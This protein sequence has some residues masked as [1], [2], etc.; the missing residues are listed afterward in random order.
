MKKNKPKILIFG[1]SGQIGSRASMLFA[2]DFSVFTPSHREVDVTNRNQVEEIINQIK[3]QQILYSAGFTYIDKAPKQIGNSLMLNTGSLHYITDKARRLDIPTHYLSTEVVFDGLKSNSPYTEKDHPN[4]VSIN[5]MTKRLGELITLDAS[6]NNSVL[7]L[8]ICY[9][10]KFDKKLD[11]AR[12]GV[13]KVIKGETFTSTN[14][15]E[16]NPIYVDYLV[17]ALITILKNKASGIYH[18]GA[19]DYTTPYDFVRRIVKRTGL[20][21]SLVLPT[22]FAEFSKTRPEKRPQHE[23]LSTKKFEKDFGKGILKSVE[24]GIEQFV[25]NYPT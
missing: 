13:S 11:L 3:P 6:K 12:F 2:K 19:T 5:G 25:K 4:P 9:S 14:D 17:E 16:I 18:L 1:G 20:D 21:E 24:E 10:A 22:T 7:R 8:I 15:Q 23:W